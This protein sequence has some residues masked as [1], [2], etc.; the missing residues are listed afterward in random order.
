MK[1]LLIGS[2]LVSSFFP[3]IVFAEDV[4]SQD[5]NP[6][7]FSSPTGNQAS[8]ADMALILERMQILSGGLS[9]MPEPPKVDKKIRI[10]G[11][12][13]TPKKKSE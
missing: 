6:Q 11:V 10:P 3:A 5:V 4:T 8:E 12:N 13:L 2:L 1:F 7:S 9:R